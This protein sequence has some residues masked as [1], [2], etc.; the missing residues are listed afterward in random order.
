MKLVSRTRKSAS[1]AMKHANEV[2]KVHYDL[3]GQAL[4]AAEAGKDMPEAPVR[5]CPVC[6]H[7]VIGDAPDQCPVCRAKGEKFMEIS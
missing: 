2:E 6:G 3:F 1:T 4:A 5:V 7:T